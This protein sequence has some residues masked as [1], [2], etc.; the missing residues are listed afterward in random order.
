MSREKSGAVAHQLQPQLRLEE[1]HTCL[2]MAPARPALA[3]SFVEL[4]CKR[5]V[6]IDCFD[7]HGQVN[8]SAATARL[9][10]PSK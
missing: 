7:N 5:V 8:G 4:L 2:K 10:T 1:A 6:L 9:C 3:D